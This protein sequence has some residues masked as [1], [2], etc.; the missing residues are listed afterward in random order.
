M[1]SLRC[2][3]MCA[4]PAVDEHATTIVHLR[5]ERMACVYVR[6]YMCV[7]LTEIPQLTHDFSLFYTLFY[8]SLQRPDLPHQY[9]HTYECKTRM[10]SA[11]YVATLFT[12]GIDNCFC[13][14][15]EREIDEEPSCSLR[16]AA[17]AAEKREEE[18]D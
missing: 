1:F 7:G 2:T 8:V 13:I 18:M 4:A 5:T 12:P 10:S 17:T 14:A 3:E 15:N 16:A 11:K 6:T 9:A